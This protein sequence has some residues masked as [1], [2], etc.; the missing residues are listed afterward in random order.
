LKSLVRL[1]GFPV[2]PFFRLCPVPEIIHLFACHFRG[3]RGGRE[4][5]RIGDDLIGRVLLGERDSCSN[6]R[7][8][9]R[10]RALQQRAAM[11][12]ETRV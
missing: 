1:S 9:G 10:A 7:N 5:R 12:A 6:G 2:R 3:V 11:A 4:G 8:A